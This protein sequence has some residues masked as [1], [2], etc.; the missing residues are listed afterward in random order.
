LTNVYCKST[1]PPILANKY[2]FSS[3]VSSRKFYVPMGSVDA[4]K[5]ATN[6]SK[7]ANQIEGYNF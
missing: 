3:N 4:Y 1:T 2:A 6:W 7:Y 5:G